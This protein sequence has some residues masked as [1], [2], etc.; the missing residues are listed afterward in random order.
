MDRGRLVRVEARA[1]H[2]Y[3]LGLS[4]STQEYQ[5]GNPAALA[6]VTDG[7]RNVGEIYALDRWTVA[8]GV[9]FDYGGRYA[10]YDYLERPGLFSPRVGVHAGARQGTRVTALLAQRMMAPGA[11]EFLSPGIAGAWLPPER[12]F[13]PLVGRDLRVQRARYLDVLF[14]HE[15][16]GTYVVGVRR[17]FQGVDNQLMTLFGVQMRSG[18]AIGRALLRRERGRR[19]RARVG[20]P[21]EH[22]DVEARAGV[23]RLQPDERPLE[24]ARRPRV[25]AGPVRR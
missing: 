22:A 25:P 24:F 11:E 16:S 12:T 8:P 4:Y 6:A 3:D 19:R 15:F 20:G 10:R 17:F 13:S 2:S 18:P 7:S 1:A 23:D 5:G 14:E 21:P 9:S